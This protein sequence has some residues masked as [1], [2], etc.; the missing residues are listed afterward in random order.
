MSI[1]L[2][3]LV[4]N[5]LGRLDTWLQSVLW[6]RILPGKEGEIEIHRVKGKVSTEDGKVRMIQ[7][8]RQIFDIFDASDAAE[9]GGNGKLVL[10][11]RGLRDA[12]LESSL[13]GFVFY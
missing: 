1:S 5:Q 10:I 7:G 11:G 9:Y 3:V 8:V 4:E 12:G 6:E 13:R 2:P